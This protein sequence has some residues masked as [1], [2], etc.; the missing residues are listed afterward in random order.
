[1]TWMGSGRV[2]RKKKRDS[3][4]NIDIHKTDSTQEE[5]TVVSATQKLPWSASYCGT[6]DRDSKRFSIYESRL[7]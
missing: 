6:T 1:M 3:I 4:R 2:K 7:Q 5:A